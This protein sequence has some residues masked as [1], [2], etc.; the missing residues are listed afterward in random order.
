MA[1]RAGGRAPDALR[2]IRI[3]RQ[4]TRNAP[5]S[6][7]IESGKTQILC[8]ATCTETVPGWLQGSGHGWI[9][10]EYSMLPASTH[11]RKAREIRVGRPDG[12]SMEIQR[13]IGRALRACVDLNKVPE[14]S[15]WLDCDVLSAD[16]GTRTLSVTGAYVALQ[17][18]FSRLL[19]RGRMAENP[20]SQAVA[21]TSV[22]M[23]RG[24]PML[25]LCYEE[26]SLA[27]VDMNVVMGAS[28]E[29][30]E[31]QAT[32]EKG[33]LARP[34]MDRLLDLAEKGCR[35]LLEIQTRALAEE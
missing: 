26:D 28:G 22:G 4:F 8:T 18:L 9:T 5:G 7:L 24:E 19:K 13:L 35:E 10:A 29:F 31:I 6:V 30:V 17:D 2:E 20:T 23:V 1:N 32:G 14:M 16:G 12:R 25:D 11:S 33:T 34:D 15:I 27:G 21:A 3:T